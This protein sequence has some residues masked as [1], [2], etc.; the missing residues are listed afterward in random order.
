MH[1]LSQG[2]RAQGLSSGQFQQASGGY[3]AYR[4]GFLKSVFIC[5]YLRLIDVFD[6]LTAFICG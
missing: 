5:V 1:E 4:F 6:S 2:N 3:Q